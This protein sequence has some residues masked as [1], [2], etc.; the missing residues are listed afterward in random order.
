MGRGHAVHCRSRW[1]PAGSRRAGFQPRPST[2]ARAPRRR[3]GSI[4]RFDRPLCPAPGSRG[5]CDLG[6]PGRC[7]APRTRQAE[8]SGPSSGTRG[9]KRPVLGRGL[10]PPTAALSG[11]RTTM[12]AQRRVRSSL[13]TPRCSVV[14]HR[15][16]DGDDSATAAAGVTGDSETA[17]S[18]GER[19]A[20]PS[21]ISMSSVGR[22]FPGRRCALDR[23]R[24]VTVKQ[25]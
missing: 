7:R 19:R 11:R 9:S 5:Q 24:E 3:N 8:R 4:R 2:S 10:H 16:H 20:A 1:Q 22:H 12:C 21:E 14:T 15:P 23:Q 17:A 25:A 13:T 6:D 18:D